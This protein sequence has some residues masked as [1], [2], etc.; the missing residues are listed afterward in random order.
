MGSAFAFLPSCGDPK[1]LAGFGVEGAEALV[2][3]GA[4][5]D[6]VAGGSDRARA[7]GIAGE[8]LILGQTFGDAKPDLPGDFSGIGIHGD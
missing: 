8:L 7:A 3:S 5:E 4:D 2:G 1:L 6:E